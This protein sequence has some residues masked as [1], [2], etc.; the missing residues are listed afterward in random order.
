MPIGPI[1]DVAKLAH[2]VVASRSLQSEISFP[3]SPALR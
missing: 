3:Q 1:I 2:L